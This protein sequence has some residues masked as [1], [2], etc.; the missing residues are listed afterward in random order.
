MGE[1]F[2]PNLSQLFRP[3][4][5]EHRPGEWIPLDP[6]EYW[7]NTKP[8]IGLSMLPPQAVQDLLPLDILH[9]RFVENKKQRPDSSGMP[10]PYALVSLRKSVKRVPPHPGLRPPELGEYTAPHAIYFDG[11][12][13]PYERRRI[14]QE[15]SQECP[16]GGFHGFVAIL[17]PSECPVEHWDVADFFDFNS[18]R[19]NAFEGDWIIPNISK[20]LDRRTDAEILFA[21]TL[22]MNSP[23]VDVLREEFG[24]SLP[25]LDNLEMDEVHTW[26]CWMDGRDA[27]GRTLRY[28]AEVFAMVHWLKEVKR[29]GE[30]ASPSVTSPDKFMGVWVG[31]VCT[32][33]AWT[34]LIHSPLPLYAL[35]SVANTHPLH[36]TAMEHGLGQSLDADEQYRLDSFTSAL[37]ILSLRRDGYDPQPRPSNGSYMYLRDIPGRAH[38]SL[39]NS[40]L[41]LLPPGDEILSSNRI[42][43]SARLSWTSYIHHDSL[44]YRPDRRSIF[45]FF[46]SDGGRR[47]RDEWTG[48]IKSTRRIPS[49]TI[50]RPRRG[51]SARSLSNQT[52]ATEQSRFPL[53]RLGSAQVQSLRNVVLNGP[54]DEFSNHSEPMH[55]NEGPTL[56]GRFPVSAK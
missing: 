18:I 5:V 29:Q 37:P 6:H 14:P 54:S 27:I 33:E 26:K 13:G 7:L 20:L 56:G 31:D 15:Y 35:F 44:L 9:G 50:P 40:L 22:Q 47:L 1:K 51:L 17:D 39:P 24:T 38:P 21:D 4:V 48:M 25:F 36:R 46:L 41:Q 30:G 19:G 11:S 23:C 34:F 52:S 16:W 55:H 42:R 3:P 45:D 12:G 8:S 49:S 10:N 2:R 53:R 43:I 28:V 32:E